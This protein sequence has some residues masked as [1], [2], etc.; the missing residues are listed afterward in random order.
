MA[1]NFLHFSFLL[2]P[3][4]V[5]VVCSVYAVAG[6]G[7]SNRQVWRVLNWGLW[8]SLALSGLHGLMYALGPADSGHSFLRLTAF[9]VWMG[10]LVQSLGVVIGAFSRRYL[11]GEANQRQYVEAFAGVLALVHLLLLANHWLILIPA[12]A[13]VGLALQRL[14]CFYPNRPFAVLASHKKTIS[15]RLADA[16]LIAAAAWSWWEVG[17]GNFSDIFKH[18]QVNGASALMQVST[19]CLVLAVMLR[20]ALL[21]VHGWLIQVM[22]APTP[23]SALLHA[24]V[25]NLGGFVLILFTPLLAQAPVARWVLVIFGL[26]T[27]VLAGLVMLTRISIK[28]KLAWSTVAQMGFMILECGL[29]LYTLAALHLVG[30]SLYKA[31][32]FLGA[33]SVVQMSKASAMRGAS[34]LQT[35]SFLLAPAVSLAVVFGLQSVWPALQ[36]PTWW[37]IVLALAW[38]PLL[39][40]PTA[41]TSPFSVSMVRLVTGLILVVGL[42][43]L[44]MVAH[45]LPL[46]V[47]DHPYHT[48]GWVAMLGMVVL[49]LV[50]GAMHLKPAELSVWRRWT[51]AGFYVDEFFTRLALSIWPKVWNSKS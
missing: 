18:V 1:S 8:S 20:T 45:L 10:I 50:L 27:A 39:W 9:G 15:D 35:L 37:G 32:V 19:V 16:L 36:W 4:L 5:L 48:A 29:G 6:Q 22:E 47:T 30:H 2:L 49:Y 12:W 42:T 33:S 46:G 26:L 24:G 7:R 17:S 40:L 21:P 23:V 41:H 44:A 51:Y 11:Q 43:L 25:V 14:L 31:H 13:G 28:V 34:S 3:T 38:A